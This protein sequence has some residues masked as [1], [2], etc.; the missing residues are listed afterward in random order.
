MGSFSTFSSANGER[1]PRRWKRCLPNLSSDRGC[2]RVRSS[3]DIDRRCRCGWRARFHRLTGTMLAFCRDR[4]N[5]V[6]F[7]RTSSQTTFV[8]DHTCTRSNLFADSPALR[9]NTP[10]YWWADRSPSLFDFETSSPRSDCAARSLDSCEIRRY[11]TFMFICFFHSFARIL[12][13]IQ[14]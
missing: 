3:F 1:T 7:R 13:N 5:N 4:D 11:F 12:F 10:W 9:I 6:R 8:A 14:F 2:C